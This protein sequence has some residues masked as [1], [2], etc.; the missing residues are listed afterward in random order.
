MSGASPS[1]L[2]R[3]PGE[4]RLAASDDPRLGG[5]G[6]AAEP[7]GR[8]ETGG[9]AGSGAQR[10]PVSVPLLGAARPQGSTRTVQSPESRLFRK[11]KPNLFGARAASCALG[12]GEGGE[13]S[14]AA[15]PLVHGDPCPHACLM[16]CGLEASRPLPRPSGARATVRLQGPGLGLVQWPGWSC[17]TPTASPW[18]SGCRPAGIWP[19][20][21]RLGDR[22]GCAGSG[23]SQGSRPRWPQGLTS[24]PCS[25][26]GAQGPAVPLPPSRGANASPSAPNSHEAMHPRRGALLSGRRVFIEEKRGNG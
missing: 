23:L 10:P 15:P 3:A 22:W 24:C 4:N 5:G 13:P 25:P 11:K 26:Q 12:C 2:A 18:I 19:S 6:G 14:E 17:C 20:K 9:Q 16:W 21:H 8:R 7:R 1:P